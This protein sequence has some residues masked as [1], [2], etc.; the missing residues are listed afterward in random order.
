[1]FHQWHSPHLTNDHLSLPFISLSPNRLSIL[2]N[3]TKVDLSA[4]RFVDFSGS[5]SPTG[6]ARMPTSLPP[7]LNLPYHYLVPGNTHILQMSWTP[8]ALA[9]LCLSSFSPFYWEYTP[10]AL[11]ASQHSYPSLYIPLASEC[12]LV[13]LKNQSWTSMCFCRTCS[14]SLWCVGHVNYLRLSVTHSFT[15]LLINNNSL[16]ARH[17]ASCRVCSLWI[18]QT[19]SLHYQGQADLNL[20][21]QTDHLEHLTKMQIPELHHPDILT[22]KLRV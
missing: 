19:Q 8:Q 2:H 21:I 20:S 17:S 11:S 6:E 13:S 18:R 5:L 14:T 10:P 15:Q 12:F 22:R 3:I 9:L 16:C 1:M 4:H 7:Y